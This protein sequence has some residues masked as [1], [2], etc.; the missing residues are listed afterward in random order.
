MG[1]QRRLPRRELPNIRAQFVRMLDAELPAKSIMVA[2]KLSRSTFFEWKRLYRE[3]GVKGLEV[4]PIPGGTPKLTDQQTNQLLRWIIGR[5]PRQFQFDFALWTRKIVGDLIR[6]MFDVEMTPQ[7]IGKLLHRIGL[8]PQRPLYR[9]YQQDLEAV[10]R[11]REEEFPAI[12]VQARE[13]GAEVYFGDEAGIRTDHHA[14]TTWAPVGQT[15]VVEVTGERSSVN[16][17]SAVSPSGALMFDVFFGGCN[18]TVFVE[19]LK[20]LMH[21]APR[22]VFLI[23]DN[24]SFHKCQIVKEYVGSL[25]GRL[26]LFFLPGYSPELNPDEWVW[27]NVKNDQL[28]RAGIG[29]KSELHGRATR[30]LERLA[31]LP[32]VIRGF[33]HDPSLAYIGM[34]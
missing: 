32:E 5:D 11:W 9:A 1:K 7:G 27:K 19:F 24:V 15:P 2:L 20:K 6:R 18:G 10:R 3:R 34:S 13:E 16:M 25:D 31:Q 23:L 33:F 28:G 21:D 22:P 8:S 30:A 4:R 29:R 17:I 14:G 12:R 26:K